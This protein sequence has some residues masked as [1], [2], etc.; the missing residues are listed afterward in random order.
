MIREY[1]VIL[2]FVIIVRHFIKTATNKP[3]LK[4]KRLL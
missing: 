2:I 3:D 4:F 1:S